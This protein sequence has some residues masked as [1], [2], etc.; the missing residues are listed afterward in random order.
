[1]VN[2]TVVRNGFPLINCCADLVALRGARS[3]YGR[4][5]LVG[6][7]CG[8][9]RDF[10]WPVVRGTVTPSTVNGK[11]CF[12]AQVIKE[13]PSITTEILAYLGHFIC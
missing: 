10:M 6:A 2:W 7:G 5:R 4:V 12:I 11:E 8:R 13:I 9:D 3:T 1:M